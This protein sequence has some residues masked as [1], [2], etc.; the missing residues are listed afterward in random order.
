[1]K[2]TLYAVDMQG[3]CYILKNK[4]GR[5]N[6]GR[7]ITK[8]LQEGM[9][10]CIITDGNCMLSANSNFNSWHAPAYVHAINPDARIGRTV[11]DCVNTILRHESLKE[12][13]L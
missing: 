12:I 9:E 13:V 10:L 6:T 1:M 8:A 11:H 4:D 2:R 3:S 5:E 7:M